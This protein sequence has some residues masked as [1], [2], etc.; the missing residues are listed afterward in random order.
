[1]VCSLYVYLY[2]LEHSMCRGV[3]H[4]CQNMQHVPQVSRVLSSRTMA[5]RHSCVGPLRLHTP[6]NTTDSA[7]DVP[8]IVW[9]AVSGPCWSQLFNMF[10]QSYFRLGRP[11]N[12]LRKRRARPSRS[13][14]RTPYRAQMAR[15]LLGIVIDIYHPVDCA[16]DKSVRAQR[17][18]LASAIKPRGAALCTSSSPSIHCDRLPVTKERIEP[19]KRTTPSY[20][21]FGLDST[22]LDCVGL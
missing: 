1:M 22:L 19:Q 2:N 4:T 6:R 12:W 9:A 16:S 21:T 7:H 11:P 14:T 17:I 13:R 5:S 18:E 15:R 20:G 10:R 8:H 3:P